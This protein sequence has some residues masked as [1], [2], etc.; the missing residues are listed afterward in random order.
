GGV[1]SGRMRIQG[2]E[3]ART[4]GFDLGLKQGNLQQTTNILNTYFAKRR[5]T[6]AGDSGTY[7][8]KNANVVM[9]L[10]VSA[11]GRLNDPMSF[12]GSGNAELS[13][14]GLGEIRLLGLLS[15]LLNF[16]A[17]RFNHLSA[18]FNVEKSNVVFSEVSVT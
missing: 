14:R 11:E 8:Q 4:L 9:D 15:E 18:N 5:G 13:G 16:T 1:T 7:V 10:D 12:V 2:P 17:L 6:A 3:N